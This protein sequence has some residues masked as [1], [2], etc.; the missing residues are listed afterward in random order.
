MAGL[1]FEHVLAVELWPFFT[2]RATVAACHPEKR[3]KKVQSM[4]GR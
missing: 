1:E 4:A 3:M 2:Q